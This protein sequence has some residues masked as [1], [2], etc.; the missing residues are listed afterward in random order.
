M[1]SLLQ[2]QWSECIVYRILLGS[3]HPSR[4]TSAPIS[5]ARSRVKHDGAVFPI[6]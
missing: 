1:K 5:G 6:G 4:R 2:G 3:P